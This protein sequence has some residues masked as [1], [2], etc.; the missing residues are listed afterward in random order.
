MIMKNIL[1]K[2]ITKGNEVWIADTARVFGRV[3]LGDNCSVWFGAV[4]RGDGDDIVVGERTNI[5]DTAVVHVDPGFPVHIGHDC[6]LGHGAI[7]HGAK[8]G[9][10]VLVGMRATILNGAVV[11]NFCIIGAHA[12]VTEGMQIP[13]YSLVLGTPA[14]VVK[15]LTPEQIEKVKRNAQVYV[16]LAK[17]YLNYFLF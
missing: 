8:L 16:D 12:L 5:Q 13:D 15:Q 17:E 6:I 14:K 9:N 11:G 10:H 1:Q 3:A 7:V 4:L 2:P